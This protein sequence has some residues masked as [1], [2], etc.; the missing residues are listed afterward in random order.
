VLRNIYD[1]INTY[2]RIV[3][4]EMSVEQITIRVLKLLPIFI[5]VILICCAEVSADNS[6]VFC[7]VSEDCQACTRNVACFWCETSLTCLPYQEE[8]YSDCA[9]RKWKT[10]S[11]PKD[12]T[13]LF[14]VVGVLVTVFCVGGITTSSATSF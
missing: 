6:S 13:A 1:V 12:N 11:E 5:I 9:V 14:I 7:R 3:N 10:C 8:L 2:A 4:T